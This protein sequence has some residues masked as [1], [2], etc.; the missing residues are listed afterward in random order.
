MVIDCLLFYIVPIVVFYIIKYLQ[1][2]THSTLEDLFEEDLYDP[3]TF[4]IFLP[5]LNIVMVVIY[6][7][8]VV[9]DFTSKIRIN[10]KIK[11]IRIK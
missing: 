6:I 10:N 4:M 11:N 3:P 5:I 9:V 8:W 1:L 7:A 2:P